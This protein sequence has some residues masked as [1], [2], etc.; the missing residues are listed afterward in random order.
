M[1]LQ[2]VRANAVTIVC[3]PFWRHNNVQTT[4]HVPAGNVYSHCSIQRRI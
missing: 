4:P 3:L 2:E 1:T